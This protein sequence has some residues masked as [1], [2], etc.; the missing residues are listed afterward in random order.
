MRSGG[1]I[2][3][4]VGGLLLAI[5]LAWTGWVLYFRASSQNVMGT[6]AQEVLTPLSD[7]NAYCPV[8]R[9][10]TRTGRT[11]EHYSNVC[12]WPAAYEVGDQVRVYYDPLDPQRVQVND[13]FGTWFVPLLLGFM[14]IVFGGVGLPMVIDLS[15]WIGRLRGES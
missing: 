2:F 7:G 10:T 1:V 3:L 4:G 11:L 13:L 5:A 12:S 15:Y 14:G 6:V 9:Y 8:I